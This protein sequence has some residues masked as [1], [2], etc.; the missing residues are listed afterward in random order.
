MRALPWPSLPSWAIAFCLVALLAP[1]AA[2]AQTLPTATQVASQITVGWN[3]GNSLESLPG[4]TGFGNPLVTQQVID[5]VKRAGFNA[6]RIPASWD[7]HADQTTHVIDP[8]WMARVKQVVDFAIND[9]LFV[10]LNIHW[11]GGWLQDHPVFASQTA[12]NV[13]QQA[14]WTQIATTFKAYDQHLL[15]AGTNEVH[16]DFGPPSTEN[17]TVQQSYLQ[18]FVNAVRATGGNNASRTL[19]V[20]TYNT[21]MQHGLNFFTLPTD[22]IANRLIVETHFYDPFDF[23]LNLTGS[24]L[25]WGAPFPPQSACT[26]AY[27]PYVTD[28]FAQVRAKWVDQGIPVIIGEYG[29]ATRPNL[30]LDARQYWLETINKTAAANNLKTFY[31]DNGALPSQSNGFAL[32]DRNTGALTDQGALDAVLRGS[33]VGNP[34]ELFTLSTTTNGSGTVTVSPLAA[35]YPGGTAV[36]LTATPAAGF[37]FA[38]WTGPLQGLTN[39]ITMKV[40]AN[41]NVVANFIP[42]G[43]GGT[44]TILREF[45][46]NAAGST[47]ADLRSNASFPNNPSGSTQLTTLEGPTNFADAYGTRIRGFVHPPVSGAYT[48]WLA[49]DDGGDLSLSTSSDPANATRIAFVDSWTNPHEY[50]KLASQQSVAINLVAG[51]KYYI[52]VVQKEGGGGDNVSVAWQGP[53]IPQ[54]IIPGIYMS[55][56]VPGTGGTTFALTVTRA[57]TGSGTVTS[58]PAGISCGATCSASFASGA[59]VTLTASAASGSTFAGWSGACTGTGACTVPMTAAKSVTATFNTSATTQTLTVTRAGSGTG[60]VTSSPT[61][62]SCGSTCSASF[63]SGTSVTLTAAAASG[64]TFAGWSGA[65]TGT[66]TCTV[67]MTAAQSVTATFN[68][69]ATSQTL[70]VTK[71]GTGTGTVTSSPAGISCGSTCSASF[72]SGTSVTLTAA[73]AGGSTFAGWSGACT[74]TGTC[75]VSMT[76]AQ[77]VT[78]T[79]NTSVTGTPCANPITFSGGNTGNFNTTG[80]VCYRTSAT[81]NGWGCSSFDGRTASVG[82]QPTTCGQMPVI[83]SAD[84]FVYFS[85]TAGSFPWATFFTW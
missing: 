8:V 27:E 14:Y 80:P 62:I 23:T 71:A 20:Q 15:F 31:W 25:F 65:C 56:F 47:P 58:S 75:T 48:F 51:Q 7:I 79:F 2:L 26:W 69:S 11:D 70:T 28:L 76:A 64:S 29:V 66:G 34:N 43:T 83:R 33:G 67:S 68:T 24:C 6:V 12:V 18:T 78:A 30:S 77:S 44:G 55:P 45:W 60:T 50:T 22:T 59:S 46:L 54:Q 40:V 16:A 61:G 17:I 42:H 21:N 57:G 49:S 72:A 81:V 84:G 74:G 63:A 36:T 52:E 38:G 82:G 13:K 41:S 3:L 4:E 85:A 73:A 35:S 19:V 53:G 32:V 9:G 37:D 10:V 1:A 5:A 39:P